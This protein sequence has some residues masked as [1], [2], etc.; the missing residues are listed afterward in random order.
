MSGPTQADMDALVQQLADLQAGLDKQEKDKDVGGAPRLVYTQRKIQKF[1][2]DL[3]K[4]EGWKM[5]VKGAL[6]NLGKGT[7]V[8]DF[9][10]SHL[11]GAARREIYYSREADTDTEEKCF[12]ILDEIYGETRLADDLEDAFLGNS[13]KANRSWHSLMLYSHW[14]S[15]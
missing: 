2:G 14:S 1:E 12:K 4:Y 15:E 7:G 6:R 11:E 10:L 9:F 3:S 5:E 8:R 13:V